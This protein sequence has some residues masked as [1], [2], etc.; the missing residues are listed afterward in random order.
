[1]KL[2]IIVPVYNSERYL[3]ACVA[4][5]YRQKLDESDFEVILVNDGS[6]DGSHDIALRLQQQHANLQIINQVNQGLSAARNTGQ[7]HAQGE[8]IWFVDSDDEITDCLHL[9]LA[10]IEKYKT[11]DILGVVIN[12]KN[13]DKQHIEY[14]YKQPSLPHNEVITGASAVIQGFDPSSAYSLILRRAF[15]NEQNL[16][17]MLGITHED[18]EF[19]YRAMA[20]AQHVVFT[21]HIAYNYYL[22]ED[23]LSRPKDTKRLLKYIIDDVEVAKSFTALAQ[24]MQNKELAS[25]ITNRRN[26]ILFGLTYSLFRNRNDWKARGINQAVVAELKTNG[27]YPITYKLD[28]WKK[29]IATLLLNREWVLK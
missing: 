11:L 27:F 5:L 21:H 2:S 1:M 7:E 29:R 26:N 23:T 12:Q 28:S 22:W 14:Q 3:E 9:L 18:V 25:A 8:Y 17:F 13:K 24:Q 4:S 19:T 15:L 6:T 20:V 16:R 10:E